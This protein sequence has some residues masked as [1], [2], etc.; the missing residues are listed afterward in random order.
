MTTHWRKGQKAMQREGE[1]GEGDH[2][3]VTENEASGKARRPFLCLR[4]PWDHGIWKGLVMQPRSTSMA[5]YKPAAP[6]PFQGFGTNDRS[7]PFSL[8]G[9]PADE[10][11][12]NLKDPNPIFLQ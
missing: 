1:G 6:S 4:M 11:V 5:G 8:G 7:E 2:D 3:P 10:S 12:R 9:F